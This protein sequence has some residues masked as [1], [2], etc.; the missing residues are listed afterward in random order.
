MSFVDTVWEFVLE[1]YDDDEERELNRNREWK[2]SEIKSRRRNKNKKYGD[3]KKEKLKD[4]EFI[5]PNYFD[6]FDT[7]KKPA[8]G[9]DN[10]YDTTWKLNWFDVRD[11]NDVSSSRK[12][13]KS[14]DSESNR[15]RVETPSLPKKSANSKKKEHNVQSKMNNSDTSHMNSL[16]KH[17]QSKRF[18]SSKRKEQPKLSACSKNKKSSNAVSGM[19]EDSGT[20]SR[21]S[22]TNAKQLKRPVR[23][24]VC[25]NESS[26]KIGNLKGSVKFG[27]S[28]SKLSS[29]ANYLKSSD[30]S[31]SISSKSS[32]KS[33]RLKSSMASNSS[34]T[35]STKVTRLKSSLASSNSTKSGTCGIEKEKRKR[36]FK[37]HFNFKEKPKYE[38]KKLTNKSNFQHSEI[39]QINLLKNHREDVARVP[40]ENDL[41]VSMFDPMNI[42]FQ[43]ADTLESLGPQ[44]QEQ[45]HSES[46][47]AKSD[48]SMV[49]ESVLTIASS[50][51]S[52]VDDR[53]SSLTG[54]DQNDKLPDT[55][56]TQSRDRSSNIMTAFEES[57]KLESSCDQPLPEASGSQI[58]VDPSLSSCQYDQGL[59]QTNHDEI[60]T[61]IRLRVNPFGTTLS[62]EIYHRE[63]YCSG[64]DSDRS[65]AVRPISLGES[66]YSSSTQLGTSRSQS[67]VDENSIVISFSGDNSNNVVHNDIA[68]IVEKYDAPVASSEVDIR[69]SD[70][71]VIRTPRDVRIANM[72]N[73]E[74]E[75]RGDKELDIFA[76]RNV[77]KRAVCGLKKSR[78]SDLVDRLG[79]TDIAEVFPSS[80][81]VVDG[82][83]HSIVKVDG[84]MGLP[85]DHLERLKGP[86]SLYAYDYD[87]SEHMDVSYAK[88]NQKPREN[89]SVRRLG[90]PP[91]LSLS[92]TGESIVIQVEASTV[93]ETDCIIRQGLW[94]GDFRPS[95]PNTP[96]IDVVGKIYNIKQTT[97]K[98]YGLHPRQTIMSLVKWGGNSRFMTIH[99]SQIVKVTDG[100]DPAQVACL[101]ECYLS[102]FQVLHKGQ[103]GSLRYR[104]NSLK[105]KTILI[106]GC[107]TN[108]MGTAMIELAFNA[109]VAKIYGTAKKKYWKKLLSNDVIPL[110]SDPMEWIQKIA[111]TIDFV[112]APNGNLRED[113]TP[114]HYRAL[115]PKYG[116]LIICGHRIVGNDIPIEEWKRDHQTPTL[117]C[118]KSKVLQKILRNSLTY[119]VYEEW[120][121]NL[122]LCKEDLHHLLKL[123]KCKVVNPEVLDRLPLNKVAKA[124]EL[125]ES[126]RLP[127][128]L[129]CEPWI[130]SKKRAVFI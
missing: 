5:G 112:L 127:G 49:E 80:R 126:K 87:S 119:D 67:I 94:W 58:A 7:S 120:E 122:K 8:K 51:P 76:K 102:A 86:Q 34:N 19:Q 66:I 110:S 25:V 33:S 59:K 116:Q 89:I 18:S 125:L 130:M 15:S 12:Q 35:I 77:W 9:P 26:K 81:L 30:T 36:S 37:G 55:E 4:K 106:L 99:P 45:H 84:V 65:S 95:L 10:Q 61:E 14:I 107:M 103:K 74:K 118:G 72:Q 3:D 42:L 97:A 13:S 82:E 27:N 23:Y 44:E 20:C 68:T 22:S 108:T 129:V 92:L 32:T 104:E 71:N 98:M 1:D 11:D 28:S 53:L 83:S 17:K 38:E 62:E 105:G 50:L 113:V 48:T 93:S 111:G 73:Y 96:G 52:L 46:T 43:I 70:S 117:V 75:D 31:T 47:S 88:S 41:S 109:G 114:I 69:R 101:T 21:K 39:S 40:N 16:T 56:E 85:S 6:L 79:K 100:L 115:V 63:K 54:K 91:S 2:S 29:N 57:Q 123:L 90:L 128:F 78:R 64:N 121:S 124:H 24:S 60:A